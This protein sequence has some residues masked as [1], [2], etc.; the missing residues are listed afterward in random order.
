MYTVQFYLAFTCLSYLYSA[1]S[2]VQQ[3][4]YY[5][6]EGPFNSSPAAKL[7][8]EILAFIITRGGFVFFSNF[9]EPLRYPFEEVS[10][11]QK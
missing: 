4:M 1:N 3:T 5:V 6:H 7:A 10:L 11:L 2:Q 8:Q 9:F